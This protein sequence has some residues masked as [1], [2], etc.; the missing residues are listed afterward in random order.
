[1]KPMIFLKNILQNDVVSHICNV[2]VDFNFIL[3][4]KNSV[5]KLKILYLPCLADSY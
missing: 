5:V 1:M 4:E 3:Y 2:L